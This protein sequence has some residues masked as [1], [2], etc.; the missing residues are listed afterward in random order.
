MDLSNTL[1]CLC[2]TWVIIQAF[3]IVRSTATP[4]KLP[5]GPKPYPII[6]NL[7]DVGDK[8]HKS[9]AMLA[10]IYGPIMCLK[11]GQVTTIIIS[12]AQMAKEVL[13][14]HDQQLSSRTI[15]D[16]LRAHKHDELG[17]AW[18]PV[19]TKWRN[20]RKIC[21]GQ[22]FSNRAL[23][24]NQDVRRMK[25]QELLAETHQSSLT[26][27]AIDIGMVAVK[28]TLNL[29]SNTVFSLDLANSDSDMAG[30]FK[31]IAGGIMREVGK[32]NLVDY[33]PLLKKIYPQ[34]AMRLTV[35]FSKLIDI[36]DRL[37]SR[38]LQLR[39]V[40]GYV[41]K[42]DML[43]TL[44]NISGDNSTE[45][46]KTT[47]E[48]LFVDLFVAGTET[49]ATT[50][51]WAMAELFQNLEALSKAKEELKQVIEKGNPIEESDIARL[52]YLQAIVKETFRLHPAI[53]FL[54]PR[55]ADADVEI[56]GYVIPEGAQLLVNAWA[57]G[58]DPSLWE[59]ASSFMPE[60]FLGSDIDVK[61]RNFELIPFGG[62]RRICPGYPLATRMLHLMLGSLIHNF[63]WKLEDGVKIE[64]MS[65]E[66]KISLTS[67]IAH[68]LRAIPIP[69]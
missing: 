45:L 6:G 16:A 30:E 25:L 19:S 57:I 47:I 17:M 58:R 36:F 38:R 53:P 2:I 7:L 37:I 61:G 8:S 59:N 52:P 65:M 22:L 5:P 14:T 4:K 49:T 40:S 18:I 28:T 55:K 51:E 34:G 56:N 13:R 11:L 41:T 31:E 67:H 39:K 64:D 69:V 48:G 60:R 27:E 43:D 20:L 29:L 35:H 3:R 33:F 54:L 10:Q 12:S 62:G 26:G 23:N 42:S 9:L 63:D 44:L 21:N 50:L 1:L 15:P 32:P 46:D 66:N 68:P 24:D